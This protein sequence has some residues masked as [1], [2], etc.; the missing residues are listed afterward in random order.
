M[1]KKGIKQRLV[2]SLVITTLAVMSFFIF[3][4][5]RY[6]KDYSITENERTINF[7][8]KNASDLLQKPL[9]NSDYLQLKNIAQSIFLDEFDYL[10]I[11]DNST[12]NIA[13]KE[14][15][16]NMIELINLEEIVKNKTA[17]ET[18][19]LELK[20]KNYTQFL[21]PVIS[22]GISSPLGFLVIGSSIDKMKSSLSGI[23]YRILTISF[24]LFLTLTL[25]IYFLS[26][27]I[28]KPIK[29]LSKT[30]DS[31]A[32]GNTSIRSD[33]K[34][35]DEI[36]IL[37][38]NFNKMADKI[39]EQI[40]SIEQY[41][42][43]LEIMVEE[44]TDELLKALD[45]IKDKDKKLNQIEKINSLN[46]IV[47]SI[48]HEIN[49]PLAIISGNLQ[50]IECK[51]EDNTF[52]KKIKVANDAVE[53]IAKLIDEINFFSAIKDVTISR[54]SFSHL[55][56]SVVEK[57]IPPSIPVH[58]QGADTDIIDSNSHLLATSIENILKNSVEMFQ[59]NNREGKITINYY[60]D[61]PFFVIEITDNAGGIKEL[62]R[63]FDPFYTTFPNKKGLGLTFVHHAIQAMNGEIKIENVPGGARTILFLPIDIP[64]DEDY[65]W[66]P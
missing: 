35:D 66:R 25:T 50:L 8:G 48:A 16:R 20:G 47:S 2:I 37:S 42:K 4:L 30:I 59:Y 12:H 27:K 6:L 19:R 52:Q 13:F 58:I 65:G 38:D 7:L 29:I 40:V 17:P 26:E 10:V 57:A 15:K 21:F 33:I 61:T 32:S 51:S 60:T 22:P 62:N 63:V 45:S 34:T 44:R 14:D 3:I 9:F 43:N 11:F 39:N 46:A 1:L 64:P 55:V 53:R 24:L 23:T 54:I 18:L 56:H 41:S 5:D 36:G 49:N 31:F 28:V